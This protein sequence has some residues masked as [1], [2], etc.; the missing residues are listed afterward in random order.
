MRALLTDI[1]KSLSSLGVE[2]IKITASEEKTFIEALN[3]DTLFIV[4]GEAVQS[5]QQMKGIFGLSNLNKIKGIL[6]ALSRKPDDSIKTAFKTRADG[7]PFELVF[8]AG[9]NEYSYRLN[10]ESTIPSQPRL[11]LSDK[12][13]V[14]SFSPNEEAINDF[15]ACSY[16]DEKKVTFVTDKNKNLMANIG[17]TSSDR[18]NVVIARNVECSVKGNTYPFKEVLSVL[19]SFD[20]ERMKIRFAE[21]GNSQVLQIETET[22]FTNF[23]FIFPEIK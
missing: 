18:A 16:L 10:A 4:K 15:S 23:K 20:P 8:Q 17:D 11:I 13:I 14:C 5:D 22:A 19:T 12:D 6:S 7:A 9:E 3:K 1:T 21:K 2:I